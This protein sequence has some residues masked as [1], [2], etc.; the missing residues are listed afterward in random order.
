MNFKIEIKRVIKG[1]TKVEY[2]RIQKYVNKITTRVMNQSNNFPILKREIIMSI[3]RD[4]QAQRL[5]PNI[6]VPSRKK[7]LAY[8]KVVHDNIGSWSLA[9]RSYLVSGSWTSSGG[10]FKL[11]EESGYDI[12]KL[13]LDIESKNGSAT[14]L[15]IGA[16]YA[17]FRS[18]SPIGIKKLVELYEPKL[19][20][21]IHIHFTNLTDWHSTL[22]K[23]VTEHA[24][25][26]AQ[27]IKFLSEDG[28]KIP[29]DVIYSQCAAYFEFEIGE[30][31][32]SS[33]E[34]LNKNGYLIFNAPHQKEE[35]IIA[36]TEK[37]NIILEKRVEFGGENG[38]LYVFRKTD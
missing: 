7:P 3:E 19:G 15:E 36:R 26:T 28:F 20:K 18:K 13:I 22:P 5:P 25:F 33:A 31:A 6:K 21:T 12:A 9:I 10:S 14:F 23:G 29:V 11:A 34:M 27:D 8:L 2:G 37:K 16:G 32:V 1:F 24:G 17:G 4:I 30:F 38:N 35:A